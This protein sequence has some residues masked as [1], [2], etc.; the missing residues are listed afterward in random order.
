M[1]LDHYGFD[2]KRLPCGK[3][4][5]KHLRIEQKDYLGR[6]GEARSEEEVSEGWGLETVMSSDSAEFPWMTM[7]PSSAWF[8]AKKG[9]VDAQYVRARRLGLAS[10][11]IDPR[12]SQV[13]A[14]CYL[15]GAGQDRN[16]KSAFEWFAKSA[17][18]GHV[19]MG[20]SCPGLTQLWSE[21]VM[22]R[23]GKAVAEGPGLAVSRRKEGHHVAE[24]GCYP[25]CQHKR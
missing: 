8:L 6:Q 3:L 16:V 24:K 19:G 2:G 20:R 5:G 23:A 13:L 10:S 9:E 14:K 1:V 12:V 18:A 21:R 17:A 7:N 15:H 11:L 25:R 4:D 22:L